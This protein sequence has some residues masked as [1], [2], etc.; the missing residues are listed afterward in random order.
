MVGARMWPAVLPRQVRESSLRAAEVRVYDLLAEKLGSGWTVFYSRPWL[1]LT[2]SGEEKDGECD[3]VVMHPAHGYIA[4]EV[5]GGGISHDE[6]PVNGS[7]LTGTG[8]ATDQESHPAGGSLEAPA[9]QKGQKTRSWP[10]RMS[11]SATESFFRTRKHPLATLA[12]TAR[13]KFS[14][15]VGSFRTLRRG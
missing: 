9:S 12:L 1:G 3:F 4:I 10:G 6:R 13:G 7:A 8:S 2:P 11:G 14:A 15:A 5:K